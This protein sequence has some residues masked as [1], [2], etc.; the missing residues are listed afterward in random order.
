MLKTM[1]SHFL[2]PL[3]AFGC[4]ISFD[5]KYDLVGL[6]FTLLFAQSMFFLCFTFSRKAGLL[7][8]Y[9]IFALTFFSLIP[10]LHYS[11]NHFIWR[12]SPVTESAYL[13]VNLLIFLANTTTFLTYLHCARIP[14]KKT[15]FITPAKNKKLSAAALL[16]LS[17][18]SFILLFYL[19]SFSITQLLFRG[20]V[21][22]SREIVVE[23]SSLSLLL[24]MI[25]RLTPVF[26]FL[27]AATQIKESSGTKTLLLILMLLSVFPT[28][29]ARYMVAFAY[30]PLALLFIPASRNA[31]VF[32]TSLIF[33]LI[34]IF[35]FLEQFRKFS[36]IS[37][38]TLIPSPDFFYAAHFDA[39]E[40]FATAVENDFITFG[41]QLLGT[42][43]FFVPR[44]IWPN[45]P[46]GS[47]HE[48]AEN[49]GYSFNNISM[50]F[51]GEGYIN[52]GAT[53]VFVFATLI[54]YLMARIDSR[55]VANKN[56]GTT[57]DYSSAVYFFLI[58]ALFFLLRGDLLSSFAYISAGLIVAALIEKAMKLI[59]SVNFSPLK[60]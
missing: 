58:G 15:A 36:G 44:T 24:G 47:G 50:P 41:R 23:S 9:F 53:G 57:A 38:L 3:L 27:Y 59:N 51:L 14:K 52:F 21:E 49:L 1:A 33:S 30:I 42:I 18:L 35:P 26:C 54:G 60:F 39:Y 28:G 7:T 22:E 40:N 5:L 45:K 46:V 37:D 43:L 10:W 56:G 29:V 16:A 48:M 2:T 17:C 34:F 32:S 12:T 6:T 8:V 20:I 31:V 19:N 55:F 25:S 13:F 11:T 4:I